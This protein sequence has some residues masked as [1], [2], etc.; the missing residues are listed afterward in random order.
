M[1]I[2]TLSDAK[3]D[4]MAL[5]RWL[6]FQLLGCTRV[7]VRA[8]MRVYQSIRGKHLPSSAF[9]GCDESSIHPGQPVIHSFISHR[10]RS[11]VYQQANSVAHKYTITVHVVIFFLCIYAHSDFVVM[12]YLGQSY[13]NSKTPKLIQGCINPHAKSE[14]LNHNGLIKHFGD[15]KS[16]LC[17]KKCFSFVPSP[18]LA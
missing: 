18:L 9:L 17:S 5:H 7:H 16:S 6:F 8:H 14:T 3:W 15:C 12:F 10:W 1:Q 2:W 11:I 13:R 4:L